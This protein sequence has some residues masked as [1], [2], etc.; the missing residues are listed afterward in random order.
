M[1]AYEKGISIARAELAAVKS[2][3][4]NCKDN[5]EITCDYLKV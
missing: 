5:R 1:K 4:D 2:V 3:V